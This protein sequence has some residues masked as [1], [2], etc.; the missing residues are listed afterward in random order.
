[1]A[2]KKV[3]RP[4]KFK[5][6][7]KMQEKVDAYFEHCK[8][9]NLPFTVTGLVLALGMT[10]RQQLIEYQS[11]D[12]FGDII[13]RAKLRIENFLEMWLFQKQ[14]TTGA[15]FNLKCNFGWI[16]TEKRLL[17]HSGSV[18]ISAINFVPLRKKNGKNS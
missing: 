6:P 18:E 17:E 2:K 14:N 16:E 12:K 1:M 4:L 15:L 3:G 11:R 8:K 9:N 7:E 5:S 10:S 13:K